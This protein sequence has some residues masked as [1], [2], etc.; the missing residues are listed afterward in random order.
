MSKTKIILGVWGAAGGNRVT[1]RTAVDYCVP[2]F[3]T[4]LCFSKIAPPPCL[5]SDMRQEGK[6]ALM[7]WE[8]GDF[9]PVLGENKST[10]GR[11]R[12]RRRPVAESAY[13][14]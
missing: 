10:P 9:Q 1:L 5:L 12:E 2:V 4:Q 11:E 14:R 13:V 6:R 3:T 8:A 7:S